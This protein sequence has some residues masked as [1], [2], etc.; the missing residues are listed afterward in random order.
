MN[1]KKIIFVIKSQKIM[2]NSVNKK[3]SLGSV[4]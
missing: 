3:T 4:F 2:F 1:F